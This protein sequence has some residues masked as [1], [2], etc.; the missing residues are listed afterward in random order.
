MRTIETVKFYLALQRKGLPV[1]SREAVMLIERLQ[2]TEKIGIVPEG[3]WPAYCEGM[4]PGEHII[5]FRNLPN[6]KQEE[7]AKSCVWQ[8]IRKTELL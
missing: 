8:S 3:I 5:A 7:V 1:R 4:F 2:E 6:E